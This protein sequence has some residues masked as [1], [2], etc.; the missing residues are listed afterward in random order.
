M[1]HFLANK[2]VKL[3]LTIVMVG[4]LIS[5]CGCVS[6]S[7]G[8]VDKKKGK[9]LDAMEADAQAGRNYFFGKAYGAAENKIAAHARGLHVNKPLYECELT[10]IALLAGDRARARTHLK[11]AIRLLEVLY[12][13]K[14]ERE[15]ASLWGK[16][17]AK[18]YKGDPYERAMLYTLYGVSLLEDGDVDNA[19]AA[20]KR[21]LLMDG[22]TE[23]HLFQSDFGLVQLLAA[24][25]FEMRGETEQRDV[26]LK[27]VYKSF[28]GHPGGR[29]TLR[30]EI[31]REYDFAKREN[32]LT[33]KHP[34][35]GI[36]RCFA[37]GGVDWVA[38]DL[39]IPADAAKWIHACKPSRDLGFN[40]LLLG[41]RG[42]G[43]RMLRT[44]EY[45]E[46]RLIVPG[47]IDGIPEEQFT[48]RVAPHGEVCEAIPF[49][50]D[51]SFQATTRGGRPM[52]NVL[53]DQAMI[54][55]IMATSG[56]VLLVGG[57]ATG[58]AASNNNSGD[59]AIAAAAIIVAALAIHYTA[60]QM[61]PEADVRSWQCLPYALDVFPMTVP[62]G[63]CEVVV[64]GWNCASPFA[65]KTVQV[66]RTENSKFICIHFVSPLIPYSS[67][68]ATSG[69]SADGQ[70][71][72]AL[73]VHPEYDVNGD[74]EI[75]PDEYRA[76]MRLIKKQYDAN[77]DSLLDSDEAS[78]LQKEREAQMQKRMGR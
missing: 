21:A 31:L 36:Q 70:L 78:S 56:N 6:G 54:R 8:L 49:L 33:E 50:G 51:I 63:R 14:T 38:A 53:R 41:W 18:V 76:A 77:G 2:T 42:R 4:E 64:T 29:E 62:V 35:I 17:S 44:G 7:A 52:D 40:A 75:S 22:D 55:N 5:S 27:E 25:C 46:K 66:E 15:A 16:E 68:P 71:L 30:Q 11:E 20:F 74:G 60:K 43:P 19:L 13:A 69:G 61:H 34:S 67:L 23:K 73:I 10:S 47:R 9:D 65:S 24:K 72:A 57:L 39:G 26:M 59:A 28:V 58:L 48:A 37:W 1:Q 3:F 45:G 12:D 32:A